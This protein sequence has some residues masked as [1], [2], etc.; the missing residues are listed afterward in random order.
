MSKKP[1]SEQEEAYN[2]IIKRVEKRFEVRTQF[3]G[4]L[5]GFIALLIA[6]LLILPN[7]QF[8][9]LIYGAW[10]AGLMVHATNTLFFEL[11]ERAIDQQL[12]LAGLID[13]GKLKRGTDQA[14]LV[15]LSEDG[16]LE[17]VDQ[18]FIREEPDADSRKMRS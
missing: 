12:A 5:V 6:G 2:R 10:F 16:E 11:R 1:V 4:H 7:I 13:P 9:Y 15:R 17:E 3:V 8:W 18:P 14:R